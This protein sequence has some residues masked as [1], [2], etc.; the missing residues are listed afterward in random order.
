MVERLVLIGTIA[1]VDPA[2]SV[3]L[4][5][6]TADAL[7][8]DRRMRNPDDGAGPSSVTPPFVAAPPKTDDGLIDNP[9][10]LGCLM[11]RIPRTVALCSMLG[12][13]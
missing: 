9:L 12:S 2:G 1:A 7:F 3:M 5:G 10:M 4:E 13:S 8:D 6:T 11:V